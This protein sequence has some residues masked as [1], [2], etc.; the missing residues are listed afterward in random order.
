MAAELS[1][2]C[3][4]GGLTLIEMIVAI[5]VAGILVAVVAVIMKRP[6]D[7]YVD[8]RRR[9]ELTDAADTALRRIAREVRTTLPNSLRQP[10]DGSGQCVEILP[11]VGGGRYRAASRSD[12]SGDILDF[13][14]ADSS[15]DVLSADNLPPTPGFATATYHLAIYNLGIPGGNA[16]DAAAKNAGNED[17]NNR[18]TIKDT[19]ISSKIELSA[20]NQFPLEPAYRRFFVIPNHSVIYSCHNG[21]LLRSTQSISAAPPAGCPTTGSI[22]VSNVDTCRFDFTPAATARSGLLSMLL[23]ISR[24]GESI[25]LYEEVHVDNVP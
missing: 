4:Q 22:L 13:A 24:D 23:G 10:A 14:A 7:G 25:T 12:G 2:S 16:Y 17:N 3:R 5:A 21:S 11:V 6:I 9:A 15:F 1:S 8:I 20:N 19:S 18:A